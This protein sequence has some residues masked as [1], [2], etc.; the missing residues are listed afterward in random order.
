M[1]ISCACFPF[2]FYFLISTDEKLFS[3]ADISQSTLKYATHLCYRR[4]YIRISSYPIIYNIT[5]TFFFK[6]DCQTHTYTDMYRLFLTMQRTIR[7][8][9]VNA[10]AFFVNISRLI[11]QKRK[12]PNKYVIA[13]FIVNDLMA[14]FVRTYTYAFTLQDDSISCNDSL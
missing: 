9:Q 11:F 8:D 1:R 12:K 6:Q 10:Y 3:F 5:C 14:L 4:I 13:N 7:G 2:Y